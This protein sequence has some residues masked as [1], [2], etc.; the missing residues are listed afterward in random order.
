MDEYEYR[1]FPETEG[2]K[3]AITERLVLTQVEKDDAVNKLSSELGGSKFAG[4]YLL[5]DSDNYKI[6][7][8]E[9]ADIK[10][11][12][13]QHVKESPKEGFEFDKVIVIWDGRPIETSHFIDET[14]R[15]SLESE[16]IKAFKN[17]SAYAPVNTVSAT[18]TVSVYQQSTINKFRDELFFLINKFHLLKMLPYEEKPSEPLSEE[19]IKKLL[20]KNGYKVEKLIA[21][22]KTVTC[23]N[24][25]IFYRSGSPKS[26]GWQVTMRDVFLDEMF[27]G[28][29]DVYFLLSRT[30]P[31]LIPSKFFKDNLEDKKEGVTLDFF[32]KDSEGKLYC[33][34]E[35]IDINKYRI[36]L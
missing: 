30:I 12:I 14:I 15:K 8:G 4:L 2:I 33:H 31:Y 29:P 13:K 10:D 6:Y 24:A 26:L 34:D 32:I 19:E 21:N 5:I 11:R 22:Q 35:S 1:E 28:N 25:N 23:D 9:T 20:S 27:S 18:L 36:K 16:C 3:R 17:F 7:I